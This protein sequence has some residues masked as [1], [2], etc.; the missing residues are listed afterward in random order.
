MKRFIAF[1][2]CLI[3]VG[4]GNKVTADRNVISISEVNA[5]VKAEIQ[6]MTC[7]GERVTINYTLTNM[8]YYPLES[9]KAYMSTKSGG[10]DSPTDD[11][12]DIKESEQ[13]KF[14][15]KANKGDNTVFFRAVGNIDFFT[16]KVE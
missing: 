5:V 11:I 15:F 2:M 7:D 1:M 12:L 14:V 9:S 16:V 3:L 4:C 10:L 8:G 13:R 6:S